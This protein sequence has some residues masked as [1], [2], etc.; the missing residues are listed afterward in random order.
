LRAD[1]G[2]S[3]TE[4]LTLLLAH[5]HLDPDSEFETMRERL[6]ALADELGGEYDGHERAPVSARSA[7][8]RI[9]RRATFMRSD[10]LINQHERTEA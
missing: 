7:Y 6:E 4:G 5:G 2:P 10:S 9:S 8:A 1:V 3:A